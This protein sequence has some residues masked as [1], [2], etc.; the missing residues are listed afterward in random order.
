MNKKGFTLI[1]I[2]SVIV[3]LSIIMIIAVP[4][5]S[6][7]IAE[8]RKESYVLAA[9]DNIFSVQRAITNQEIVFKDKDKVLY[10]PYQCIESESGENNSPNGSFT[11]AFVV[12]TYD[13]FEYKYYW[14]SSDTAQTGIYLSEFSTL[15]TDLVKGDMKQIRTDIGIGSRRLILIMN[16][17]DCSVSNASTKEAIKRIDEGS[18]HDEPIVT[19]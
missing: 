7:Y 1:E 11:D 12:V 10:V 13:G 5:V 4:A 2:L 19:E 18:S 8:K 14:T 17:K 9:K 3:I 16:P 6:E 15:N